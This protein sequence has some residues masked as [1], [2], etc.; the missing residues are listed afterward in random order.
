CDQVA[1]EQQHRRTRL[2]DRF[3]EGLALDAVAAG[4]VTHVGERVANAVEILPDAGVD[5]T[6]LDPRPGQQSPQSP[7][8][9]LVLF[10]HHSG[11]PRLSP[12]RMCRAMISRWISLVPSTMR[13]IR[14]SR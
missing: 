12:P 7:Q 10:F 4:Q 13:I 14:A 6:E 2:V 11:E 9:R 5:S 8:V 3:E 1:V